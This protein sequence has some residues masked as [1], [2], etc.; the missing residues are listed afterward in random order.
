[1]QKT[2]L[3]ILSGFRAGCEARLLFSLLDSW[4]LLGG[5][6]HLGPGGY[7]ESIPRWFGCDPLGGR[8]DARGGQAP[9]ARTAPAVVSSDPR[10]E[11][12]SKEDTRTS[13]R[14]CVVD[15]ACWRCAPGK[16]SPNARPRE[17]TPYARMHSRSRSR[18]AR[19]LALPGTFPNASR[20]IPPRKHEEFAIC[21]PRNEKPDEHGDVLWFVRPASRRPF[22]SEPITL[23]KKDV[24]FWLGMAL[25]I[26]PLALVLIV[27]AACGVPGE[28]RT[29]IVAHL[30]VAEAPAVERASSNG[31]GPA[32]EQH[33]N[34]RVFFGAPAKLGVHLGQP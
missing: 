19:R 4:G 30:A 2:V 1:M 10:R 21:R 18:P 6:A 33:T 23:T 24:G 16:Q 5:A 15:T 17:E 32:A 29:D 22:V 3:C 13:G 20:E 7:P 8:I 26:A 25:W 28:R 31:I 11:G 14:V 9:R 34:L 12:G 27:W